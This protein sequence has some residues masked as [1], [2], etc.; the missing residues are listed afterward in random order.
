MSTQESFGA[1]SATVNHIHIDERHLQDMLTR[2]AKN[3]AREALETL[4][5]HD[6]GA[7]RD[8]QEL[9]GL[10]DAWRGAKRT[11]WRTITQAITMAMLGALAAGAYFN[12]KGKS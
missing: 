6:D 12:I 8:V 3:G 2:A 4:G 5:L 7:G 11:V 1:P 9:R 10:L